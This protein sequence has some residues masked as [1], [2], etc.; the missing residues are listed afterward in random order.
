MPSFF[1]HCKLFARFDLHFA[2]PE[3]KYRKPPVLN[4][5]RQ[6]ST[7]LARDLSRTV[8]PFKNV[9]T[10]IDRPRNLHNNRS[11]RA[12]ND[13]PYKFHRQIS[14]FLHQAHLDLLESL[15][16][17]C[18]PKQQVQRHSRKNAIIAFH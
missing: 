8:S 10:V 6:Q 15:I 9:G 18:R 12:I 7:G 11:R 14:V 1:C 4:W 2:P 13:R 16:P 17:F 5:W 3:Q